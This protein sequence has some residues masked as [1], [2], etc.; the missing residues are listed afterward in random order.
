[1]SV[2]ASVVANKQPFGRFI[3]MLVR[4]PIE[5]GLKPEANERVCLAVWFAAPAHCLAYKSLAEL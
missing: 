5:A 4:S 3:R 2:R 1:M